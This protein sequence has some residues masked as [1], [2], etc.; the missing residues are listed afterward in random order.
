M[1]FGGPLLVVLLVVIFLAGQGLRINREYE[2][3]VVYRLGRL[4][5]VRGPGLFLLIPLVDRSVKVDIRVATVTLDTQE[6]V[7]SDGVP[8]K[9][10]A[11]LWYKIAD[12]NLAVNGVVDPHAAIVQAAETALR[13]VIGQHDLD[14][15]L[16]NRMGVNAKLMELLKVASEKWGLHIDAVEMRDLDIPE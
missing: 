15:L 11:G 8:V 1:I 6:T 10:N 2:R 7:S 3:A 12:A 16:K 13:E 9:V 4:Q 14:D 5:Q